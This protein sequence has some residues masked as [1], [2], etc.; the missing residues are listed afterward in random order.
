MPE[1]AIAIFGNASYSSLA[2]YCLCHDSP[3]I[4]ACFTVDSTHCLTDTH[5]GLPLIPF[6]W[7]ER[8]HPPETTNL[9]VPIGYHR[10]NTLRRDRYLD[11]KARG[12]GFISYVSSR[13]SI[14]PDLILG[15]NCLIYERAIIQPSVAIG[16]DTIIRS[17]AHVSY[18]CDIG[19]HVYIG[20][21]VALAGNVQVGDQSILGVGSVVKDGIHLAERSIIAPGAVVLENTEPGGLYVGNPARKVSSDSRDASGLDG[22]WQKA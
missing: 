18:R 22:H 5:E 7:M 6:E 9:I 17:G 20:A 11:A 16:N 1:K 21:Q 12:Y 13:A 8:T 3:W 4:I 10:Q 14:W 19:D 15:E 2:W